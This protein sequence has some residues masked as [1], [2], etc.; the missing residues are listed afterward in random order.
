MEG[1]ASTRHRASSIPDVPVGA[2]NAP[3]VPGRTTRKSPR[4]RRPSFVSPTKASLARSNP[5]VLERRNASRPPR[6]D[7]AQAA[8]KPGSQ[9]S[10]GSISEMLTAQ[11]EGESET[12]RRRLA[13]EDSRNS[14]ARHEQSSIRPQRANG[15]TTARP[16]RT[17]PA[18]SSPRPLPPRSDREEELLGPFK[19][20]A[21]RRSPV[22]GTMT[23]A[24]P[25]E[26]ELP[27]TPTEKGIS[28]LAEAHTPS[29]G[30]HN[31]PS[32]RPRRH[33]GLAEKIRSS[34][35]K[36]PPLRP[37]TD[38]ADDEQ[39]G[40]TSSQAR[41]R[42]AGKSPKKFANG[43]RARDGESRP[44]RPEAARR[45]KEVDPLA[46][47]KALR[48]SLL[49]EIQALRADL[50]I[51][52]RGNEQLRQARSSQDQSEDLISID[53]DAVLGL[54]NRRVLSK[55][56]QTPPNPDPSHP[57]LEVALEPA[58]F[59]PFGKL[60]NI[61]EVL[62]SLNDRAAED[63]EQSPPVSH[64][65]VPMTLEQEQPFLQMF[66]PLSFSSTTRVMRQDS[67]DSSEPLLH[68]HCITASS[69]P[70]G[71]FS[72]KID[73]L[74]NTKTLSVVELDVPRLE[75]AAIYEL[76]PFIDQITRSE[77]GNPKSTVLRRNI[78]VLAWAMSDWTRV[79]MRRARLWCS[80]ENELG[81]WDGVM[82]CASRIRNGRKGRAVS[83][84]SEG[85]E[86]DEEIWKGDPPGKSQ[87]SGT[88]RL[89]YHLGRTNYDLQI[90]PPGEAEVP[91][92]QLSWRIGFDWTGE[93]QSQIGVL[94]H[95]PP[96]CEAIFTLRGCGIQANIPRA[97]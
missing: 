92:L 67:L 65:P 89:L 13:D 7:E 8:S 9:E 62:D 95:T 58:L 23:L 4:N 63:E 81:S 60:R 27:P 44:S 2:S 34:P 16:H 74:V 69:N 36:H 31:T 76:G 53:Q 40:Y 25:G 24:D 70:P 71:F 5:D 47:K 35:L 32:K 52:M 61:N 1:P 55:E 20:R 59:L 29:S 80:I 79:A 38:L 21:L 75:P 54:L 11:L 84:S 18:K 14:L 93:A 85:G 42:G 33:K 50:D 82:L 56:T 28:S 64:E 26:P 66:L 88:A 49:D 96:K 43:I 39:D 10:N 48:D 12:K 73:M 19:G 94:V 51:A 30:I 46:P 77:K 17:T 87:G 83:Q 45:I 22:P 41:N 57:L 72:A 97:R 90:R 3:V 68:H 91:D 37:P 6:K 15:A 78:S 86:G